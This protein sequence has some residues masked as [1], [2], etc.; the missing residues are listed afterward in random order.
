M[1]E[2]HKTLY[3]NDVASF[4][5]AKCGLYLITSFFHIFGLA[6]SILYSKTALENEDNQLLLKMLP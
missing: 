5:E 3:Y 2:G 6:I 1:V 4:F